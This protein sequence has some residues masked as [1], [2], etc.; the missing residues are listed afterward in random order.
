MKVKFVA[1]FSASVFFCFLFNVLTHHNIQ[2]AFY[3]SFL[4][5]IS[6]TIAILSNKKLSGFAPIFIITTF[7]IPLFNFIPNKP[8]IYIFLYIYL[9][10]WLI[11]IKINNV[12]NIIIVFGF[13]SFLW[14]TLISNDIILYPMQLNQERMM[15]TDRVIQDKISYHQ[16]DARYVPY[17]IRLILFNKSVYLY[18]ALSSIA[19]F[20]SLKNLSDTIL[21]ANIYP[22]ILG[23]VALYKNKKNIFDKAVLWGFIINLFIIGINKSPDKFNSLFMSAPLFLYLIISGFKKIN[24]YI[25]AILLL[26]SLMLITCPIL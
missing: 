17:K 21:A 18:S 10:L 25:Y 2:Y 22:L 1:T 23:I 20:L 19:Y 3:N 7:L 14:G 16:K 4:F 5:A 9:T 15:I 26:V 13:V 8:I 24:K 6:L 11:S 12:R